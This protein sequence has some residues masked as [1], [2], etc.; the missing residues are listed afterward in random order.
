MTRQRLL[1]AAVAEFSEWGLHGARIA[2]I[3]KAAGT[4]LQAIY[5]HF[6][7]KDKLYEATLELIFEPLE[8]EAAFNA[9]DALAPD[10]AIVHLISFM[11]R[12][13]EKNPRSYAL[14]FD[15]HYRHQAHH[16]KNL[17]RA[18]ALFARLVAK[19]ENALAR[20][21]A[22]G[23]FRPDLDATR[24]YLSITA[25]TGSYIQKIQINSALLNRDFDSAAERAGWL[26]YI[27]T[28]ILAALS[29][30][31]VPAGRATSKQLHASLELAKK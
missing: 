6:G 25:L 15:E 11:Q 27:E 17:S 14:L 18:Q 26:S 16:L 19:I 12:Q 10:K 7:D 13:Y 31:A 8:F 3:A 21:V 5:Y 30:Q 23:L 4:N 1:Q 28:L 2:R 29:P 24:V 9:L 22:L 20:G